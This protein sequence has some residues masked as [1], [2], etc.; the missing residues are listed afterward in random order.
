MSALGRMLTLANNWHWPIA[1]LPLWLAKA[2][3]QVSLTGARPLGPKVDD[4]NECLIRVGVKDNPSD[5]FPIAW[6]SWLET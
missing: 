6:E 1:D 3:L 4:R 5:Y 2:P